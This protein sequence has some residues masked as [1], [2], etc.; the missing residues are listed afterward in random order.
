MPELR[1]GIG[2]RLGRLV[3]VVAI[4]AA[5]GVTVLLVSRYSDT[6]AATHCA[7]LYRS[8]R[9]SADTARVDLATLEEVR[10]AGR[11]GASTVDC[12]TF[13]RLGKAR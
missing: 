6:E 9:D 3:L 1:E 13:R 11:R 5:A 10:G 7:V 4:V 8:A 2:T 12:G